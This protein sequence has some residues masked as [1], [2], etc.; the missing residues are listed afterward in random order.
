ML[1]YI[2]ISSSSG[3]DDADGGSVSASSVGCGVVVDAASG[4]S[5]V[6]DVAL[7]ADVDVGSDSV[8]LSAAGVVSAAA[9]FASST[10]TFAFAA[11]SSACS[12]FFFS[13]IYS[14]HF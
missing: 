11:L 6:A 12:S 8:A 13:A 10:T 2:V 7:S 5:V 14:F 3:S 1:S 9:V 4:D